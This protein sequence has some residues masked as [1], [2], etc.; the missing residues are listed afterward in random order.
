MKLLEL[1]LLGPPEV[2]WKGEVI[3]IQRR[4]PR[5]LL[6][7]LAARG[8][9]VGRQ[10]L[11]PLFWEDN[12]DATS[13]LRLRET[14][15]KLRYSLPMP[16]IVLAEGDRVSLDFGHVQVDLA[17]FSSLAQSIGQLPWKIPPT[18]PLPAPIFD[19]LLQAIQ[20]WRSPSFLAGIELPNSPDLEHWHS[21][22]GYQLGH[23]SGRFMERLSDHYTATGEMDLALQTAQL[24][25]VHDELDEGLHVR[26]IH[27][28]I[29]LGRRQEALDHYRRVVELFRAELNLHPGPQLEA[30]YHR[31]HGNT[32]P[33]APPKPQPWNVHPGI[34]ARFVG[35]QDILAELQLAF[36]RG[37]AAFLFGESGLGKTR[38]VREFASRLESHHRLIVGR[39]RPTESS[40]PFQPI[41]E[42]ARNYVDTEEWLGLQPVW[43]SQIVTLLPELALTRNDLEPPPEL[44]PDQ[45]R[46]RLLEAL[47]RMVLRLAHNDRL[48]FFLDDAQWADEATIAALAYMVER[49][50]FDRD[51]L[52]IVAARSEEK[53]PRLDELV[54]ILQEKS[55]VHTLR[56]E[57]FDLR[58]VADLAR[59]VVGRQPSPQ[60]TERLTRD[61]GGNPL[62]ILETL[63]VLLQ[64]SPQMDLSGDTLLPLSEDLHSLIRKRLQ[65]LSPV[66]RL[67]LEAASLLG[68]EFTPALISAALQRPADEI[69]GALEELEAANLVELAVYS[70]RDL[71]YHFIHDKF[72]EV[73]LLEVHPWR[74]QLLHGQIARALEGGL[75]AQASAQSAVLA[76]HYEAAH[77]WE[78]AF[79]RWIQ[80]GQRA[81][82]VFSTA[83]AMQAFSR[84][85]GMV[86][87]LDNRLPEEQIHQLY[88]LWS[89]LAFLTNDTAT[90]NRINNNQLRLGD[91][92]NS[93]LLIGAALDGLGKA[94]MTENQF[95]QGLAHSNQAIVYLSQTKNV[96]R[97]MEATIARGVFLYMLNRWD[98]AIETF[99][100]ALAL[101][102][103]GQAA[104]VSRARANAHYQIAVINIFQG[105]PAHGREHA[106][107]SLSSCI[108][109]ERSHG[110]QVTAY[111]A[112][113]LSEY[114]LGEFHQARADARRGME[115]AER[116]QS[117][118]MLG[119]LHAYRGII[120]LAMGNLE[121]ALDH[122]EQ[123]I[124]IGNRYN[125]HE[126]I[127][128][129]HR[130]FGDAFSYLK[131][132]ASA[133]FH[134]RC[135]LEKSKNQFIA[136]DH[137]FRLGSA[138]YLS[139]VRDEGKRHIQETLAFTAQVG[140]GLIAGLARITYLLTLF[141]EKDWQAAKKQ[142]LLFRD[143][144]GQRSMPLYRIVSTHIWGEIAL[145]EGNPH[146]AIDA[147]RS[148]ALE[149]ATMGYPW[150]EIEAQVLMD[151]TLHALGRSEDTPRQRVTQLLEQLSTKILREPFQQAFQ[152]YQQHI[153][154]QFAGG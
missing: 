141:I 22:T 82:Q 66:A 23:T 31:L 15:N 126:S 13:R 109:L 111:S 84:A 101:G 110:Q 125:H 25:L 49:P 134:Y 90:L 32:P 135:A 65:S 30:L 151:R 122:A 35:R 116:V 18:E 112:L 105:W 57:R 91:Q 3:T 6:F 1:L 128:A 143:E 72:R 144:A 98:E 64:V 68:T 58:D 102:S 77:D 80:A 89:D 52:V 67:V 114:F 76:Y 62:F 70:L 37:G 107:R 129:G 7:Y 53:N 99:D 93:P 96:Y 44:P 61:S 154:S 69:S 16:E 41:I 148:S 136:V 108:S 149:T 19:Q 55:Q 24:A 120:E 152:A 137:K 131:D 8:Q 12:D 11:L 4:T 88:D 79:Q 97:R 20:L 2:R 45:A 133:V 83:E 42:M 26:V 29:E 86:E 113:A 39:C 140:L 115:L 14:L 73:L 75:G 119:Y 147:L 124:E 50:P 78:S 51:A 59:A 145:S 153:I 47:R 17:E 54:S 38:L 150:M 92:R 43:A 74:E 94:C 28:L 106:L 46:A 40:L 33:V 9:P 138:L 100:T 103:E 87:Q 71:R 146:L 56:L 36:R 27:S 63:R 48:L 60:F 127:A 117:W 123:A 5:A 118:R 132:P 95:E 142:I 85:E 130:I 34:Q 10:E 21:E 139:N 104:G 81:E 121:D